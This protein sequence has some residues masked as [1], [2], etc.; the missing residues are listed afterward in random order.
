MKLLVNELVKIKASRS[1]KGMILVFLCFAVFEGMAFGSS[2]VTTYGFG[3]P[4]IWLI[5]NGASGF[6]L[7]AVIVAALI[8]GE[9]ESGVIGN[10]LA[11]GVKRSRYFTGK[12]IGVSGVSIL[13]YLGGVGVLC[14]LKSLTAGFDPT[15][16]I[17]VD[18]GWKV[19][20]YSAGAIVSILSYLAVFIFIAY[21]F[22]EAVPTFIAAVAVTVVDL[23]GWYRGPLQ[24]AFE[25][26]EFC[27]ADRVLSWDFAG[28]FVPCVLIL[29]VFLAAAYALFAVQDVN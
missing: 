3:A 19:L 8:A 16:K 10:A 15:G 12:V 6:F 20:V 4:F 7:Y 18:Y 14:L 28:L 1:V 5:T 27:E 24:I 17:F 22:R 13:I 26:I 2:P 29:V 23:L 11:S 9:L 25:T 21:L